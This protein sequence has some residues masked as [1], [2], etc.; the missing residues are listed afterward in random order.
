M[1]AATQNGGFCGVTGVTGVTNTLPTHENRP[2]FAVTPAKKL[3]VTGVTAT[4]AS[5]TAR[6]VCHTCHT[7]P[8]VRCDSHKAGFFIGEGELCHT[9]HTCHTAKHNFLD[10]VAK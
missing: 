2:A 9:R 10:E 7:T 8:L 3:G 6:P 1:S 5:A 4:S